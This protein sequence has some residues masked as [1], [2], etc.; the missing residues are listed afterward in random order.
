MNQRNIDENEEKYQS[1]LREHI[2]KKVNAHMF[3]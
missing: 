2:Y 1:A 3:E